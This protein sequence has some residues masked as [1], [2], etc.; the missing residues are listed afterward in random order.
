MNAHHT[1]SAS[2]DANP[3]NLGAYFLTNSLHSTGRKYTYCVLVQVCIVCTVAVCCV[4]GLTETNRKENTYLS[5]IALLAEFMRE[6]S[7]T[8]FSCGAII[9][10]QDVLL[11]L[12]VGF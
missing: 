11:C 6:L 4:L 1:P 10:K 3:N 5:D 2:R 12:L 7:V 8:S 9:M